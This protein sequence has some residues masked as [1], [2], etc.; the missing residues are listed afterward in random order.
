MKRDRLL[1]AFATALLLGAACT[2]A[3]NPQPLPPLEATADGGAVGGGFDASA[4]GDPRGGDGGMTPDFGS[5]DAAADAEAPD[6]SVGD[7]GDA[8]DGGG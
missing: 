5:P 6:A 4:S 1:P 2:S 3:L 8:G 7:A